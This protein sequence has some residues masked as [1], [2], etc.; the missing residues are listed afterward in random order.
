MR[1]PISPHQRLAVAL[2]FLASG[3]SDED[4]K[5]L[6][7]IVPNTTPKFFIFQI[8]YHIT[9]IFDKIFTKKNCKAFFRASRLRKLAC[10]SIKISNLF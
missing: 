3:N 4:L 8:H 10:T 9:I 6:T 5:F 2:R 1:D 7:A